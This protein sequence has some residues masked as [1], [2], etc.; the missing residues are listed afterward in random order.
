MCCSSKESVFT[1]LSALLVNVAFLSLITWGATEFWPIG[2][3]LSTIYTLII[4]AIASRLDS[5]QRPSASIGTAEL[6]DKD[7]EEY[8]EG[9]HTTMC[10]SR[11]GK[12]I[13]DDDLDLSILSLKEEE[14]S[15][16]VN[17]LYFLS[18]V[19]FSW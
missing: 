8:D 6:H 5:K 9:N 4:L 1:W 18:V 10:H 15:S 13:M 2:M 19:S 17:L 16:L 7:D 3:G 11:I 12:V 14:V